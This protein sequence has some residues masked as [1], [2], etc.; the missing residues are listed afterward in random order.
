MPYKALEFV[1][2]EVERV[3]KAGAIRRSKSPYSSH[4]VIVPK[5]SALGDPPK[6]RLYIEYRCLNDQTKKDAFPIPRH[7]DLL[8]RLAK[9]C[10]FSSLDLAFGYHLVPLAQDAVQKSAFS[11]PFGQ[12]EFLIMAFGRSNGMASFFRLM[13]RIFPERLDKDILV[14]L[15]DII[16][17][18]ES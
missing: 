1:K 8:H 5:N 2:T 16:I 7:Q 15:D 10:F 4:I 14:Y 9:A 12:F 13:N 3:L 6:F 17:F 11:A 18:T